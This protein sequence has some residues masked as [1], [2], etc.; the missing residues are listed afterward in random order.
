[1]MMLSFRENRLLIIHGLIDENVHFSHTSLLINTL[2]K[3]GKPYQLQVR[4]LLLFTIN[5]K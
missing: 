3:Y 4:L 1:M 5:I 2:I